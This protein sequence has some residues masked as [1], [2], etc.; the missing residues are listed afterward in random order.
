MVN[1]PGIFFPICEL[2]GVFCLAEV[3]FTD[4][5]IYDQTSLK[6]QRIL[7]IGK[8]FR[9]LLKPFQKSIDVFLNNIL[10]LSC[11]RHV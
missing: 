7:L 3:K 9:F 11:E 2:K 1:A 6:N 5:E 10:Q 4:Q 8:F